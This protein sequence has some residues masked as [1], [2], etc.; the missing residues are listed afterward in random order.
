MAL[1]E[2]CVRPAVIVTQDHMRRSLVLPE[3]STMRQ[4]ASLKRIALLVHLDFTAQATLLEL[5]ILMRQALVML[6][7]SVQVEPRTP[8]R[9]RFEGYLHCP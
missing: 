3:P 6:A 2:M 8:T 9:H 1:M 7:T 4:E 5:D